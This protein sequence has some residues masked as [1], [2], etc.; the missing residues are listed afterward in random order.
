LFIKKNIKVM[1]AKEHRL[2]IL[3]NLIFITSFDTFYLWGPIHCFRTC[4]LISPAPLTKWTLHPCSFTVPSYL[5]RYFPDF[6][7]KRTPHSYDFEESFFFQESKGNR[8]DKYWASYIFPLFGMERGQWNDFFF[9][10]IMFSYF[11]FD[12]M[13]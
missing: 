8:R 10:K 1:S 13:T 2:Y 3:F 6:T 7:N 9:L 11:F 4:L 12:K 5:P